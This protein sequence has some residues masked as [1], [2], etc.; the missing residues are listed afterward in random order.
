MKL[1]KIVYGATILF[2][3]WLGWQLISSPDPSA[4][5]CDVHHSKVQAATS[6]AEAAKEIADNRDCFDQTDVVWAD[7]WLSVNGDR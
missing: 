2:F 3:C 1:D 7:S 5:G 6:S 4:E